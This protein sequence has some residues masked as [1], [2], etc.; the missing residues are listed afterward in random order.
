MILKDEVP[1]TDLPNAHLKPID[2]DQEFNAFHQKFNKNL[3]FLDFLSYQF[4]PKVFE[5]YYHHLQTYGDV[6]SIP[7][8]EFFY[9][10]KN[11]QEAMIEIMH[12]KT[13]ITKLEYV[14]EP[15]ENGMRRISFKLNGQS[16]VIEIRDEHIVIAR[17]AN[18]KASGKNEVGAPLQGM[19]SKIFVKA[20]E[21]VKK[22]A[23]LFTI[24]AMKM[25]TTITANQ[26][27]KIT[28]IQLNE[29]KMVDA[30]DLVIEVE[31]L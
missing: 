4:Y 23:P 13:I 24:E 2:F 1:Y 15:D 16:R 9:G 31:S 29:G 10:M 14:S 5:E 8:L 11:G 7:S 20:G 27:F 26:Q 3:S 6:S 17:K 28:K 22:N 30:D 21:V 25:E 19:I 18:R 12:G